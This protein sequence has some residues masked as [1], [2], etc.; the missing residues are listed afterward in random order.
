MDT[1]IESIFGQEILDSRGNPTVE[2]EVVLGDGS[3]GRAAVPSGASTG[4]HE[5]LELRDGDKSRY[6]GKGVLKAVEH[7][8]KEI[9][10]TLIGWDA[11][12]QKAIDMALL[13]LDGTQNKS[14]LGANAILGT[15]LAVAKAAANSFGLPLYRYIG[16]VYAHVLPVP[17]ALDQP[18][19]NRRTVDLDQHPVFP[20]A[21]MVD[22]T[23]DQFLAGAGFAGDQHG[24]IG[25][26]HLLDRLEHFLDG[27]RG[28]DNLVEVVFGL[29]FLLQ[30]DVRRLQT[31]LLLFHEHVFGN[32]DEHRPRV[33]AA[34]IG[35]GPPLNPERLAVVLAPQFEHDAAGVG[36]AAD[37]RERFFETALSIRRIRHERA[38]VGAGD[39]FRRDAQAA[40]RGPIGSDKTG[41]QP[42]VHIGD[43][44]LVE[45]VAEPFLAFRQRLDPLAPQ[46]LVGETIVQSHRHGTGHLI[47]EL[48]AEVIVGAFLLR[49]EEQRAQAVPAAHQR[50]RAERFHARVRHHL[51]R[52][53]K[54]FPELI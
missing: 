34:W 30:V 18:R 28:A 19:R 3:W 27:A 45:E 47:E 16:G 10:E 37:G 39:L 50:E 38:A 9:A 32:V 23:G 5:A 31:S 12:E 2:V 48:P 7:V 41:I 24:R 20:I 15:S 52:H 29:D 21:Q 43:R 22:G 44:R 36:P 13:Q 11:I 17:T 1:T 53:R 46:F 25:R 26:R 8:N 6:N 4:T 14:K 54:T 40:H 42:F 33:G 51:K 35:L 49:H